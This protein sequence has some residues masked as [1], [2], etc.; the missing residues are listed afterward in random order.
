MTY[1]EALAYIRRRTRF[2][3][4]LGLERMRYL[5]GLLDNP[6]QKYPV[7]HIA[8]TNGKGS[9]TAL[10]ASVL[11]EAGYKVGRF[12]SPHLSS[13]TERFSINDRSIT[14]E[15][16]ARLVS[17]VR[18]VLDKAAANPVYGE[19]TEFE[20]G[21]VLACQ[22][23]AEEK[24]GIAVF[25]VGMGGRLDATNVVIPLVSGISHIALDHQ[26]Y[27]GDDLESIA[28]EKAGIIKPYRPVVVG[29]QEKAVQRVFAD[30]AAKMNAP[31]YRVG[32]DI[33]IEKVRT[34]LT[35][36][37]LN[38]KWR[39]E[40]FIPVKLKLIGEHQAANAALAFGLLT[41]AHREGFS[42]E[43][44]DLERGFA[45]VRWPGRMEYLP[46]ALP[47]LLD[48]AHNPDGVGVLADNLGNLFAGKRIHA[49][50]G[51][52]NN[53]P[54]EEMAARLAPRVHKVIATAVPDPKTATPAR[55]AESF[56][57]AG[58]EAVE[59]TEPLPALEY[60]VNDPIK[61]DLLLITGSLYLIG[62]LRPKLTG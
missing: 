7:I 34:D 62:Y 3:I 12:T 10:T 19:P 28:R 16:L 32:E 54:V 20:V 41:L 59:I 5:L 52:L 51:I 30:Y 55:T 50:I 38:L 37:S 27:L 26:E 47:V 58:V 61:P 53:R 15:R 13:Y 22:Y 2:G 45:R 29:V 57:A 25:E 43:W 60:A 35:G 23:F 56:R 44:E 8:G 9:T 17:E 39:S 21:T 14:P 4:K 1:E 46:G 24:V 49:V 48:G 33:Q 18:P 6:H 11:K 36:T 42:W 40:P 31:L